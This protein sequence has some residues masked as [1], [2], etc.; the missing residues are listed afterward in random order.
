MATLQD[1]ER[2]VQSL[3]DRLGAVDPDLRS[4][5]V[6]E[7]TV[8]CRVPDLDVVFLGQLSDDGLHD[9]QTG[10]DSSA[11]VKLTAC[12]DDLV[13]LAEGRLAVPSAWATGKLK[14]DASLGD[15]LKLRNLL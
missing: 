6:R 1:C 9:I 7:R 2:A 14:V 10:E 4:R 11:Q 8:S 3:V 12:S 13:A 15:L 5:F